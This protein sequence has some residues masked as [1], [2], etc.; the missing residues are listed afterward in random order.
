MIETQ[1]R[2]SDMPRVMAWTAEAF[3]TLRD[4]REYTITIKERKKPRS[5]NANNYAWALIDKLADFYGL[6][7]QYVYR[8]ALQNIG[9]VSVIVSV[10]TEA[11][12]E[13]IHVWEKRGIGWQCERVGEYGN[14]TDLKCI[15]GSSAF[16]SRQMSQLT[17]SIVQECKTVGIETM[18][19]EELDS[20]KVAWEQRNE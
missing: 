8:M 19:P 16:D 18:T 9:G 11:A 15:Y 2:K 4:N 6:E 14:S 5:M 13:V 3:A 1:F 12:D 7:P 17:D 10:L 20:L